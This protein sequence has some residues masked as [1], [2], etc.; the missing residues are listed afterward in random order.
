[1]HKCAQRR[2]CSNLR[3]LLCF[4]LAL[5]PTQFVAKVDKHGVALYEGC[6]LR[7]STSCFDHIS[8]LPANACPQQVDS[9]RTVFNLGASQKSGALNTDPNMLGPIG[10]IGLSLSG[11]PQKGRPSCG[12][13][14]IFLKGLASSRPQMCSQVSQNQSMKACSS[15][16]L[17]APPNV[18]SFWIL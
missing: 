12:N 4:C 17:P 15:D 10:P 16:G 6:V 11:H 8:G 9:S 3:W 13:S 2:I 5:A 7:T 18:V 14:H 1:M